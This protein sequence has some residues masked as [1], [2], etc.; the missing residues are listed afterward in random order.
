[1]VSKYLATGKDHPR[2]SRIV[3]DRSPHVPTPVAWNS[4]GWRKLNAEVPPMRE[5]PRRVKVEAME[6]EG[7]GGDM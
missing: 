2:E 6:M 7:K 4:K 1:M 3:Y 5:K